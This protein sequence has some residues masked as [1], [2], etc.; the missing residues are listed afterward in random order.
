MCLFPWG[1]LIKHWCTSWDMVGW[2]TGPYGYTSP[3]FKRQWGSRTPGV[4][5]QKSITLIRD[6]SGARDKGHNPLMI[7]VTGLAESPFAPRA[8]G[9][10]YGMSHE[11][12]DPT[13][14]YMVIG[15]DVA[16]K[17][18]LALIKFKYVSPDI[19]GK[20]TTAEAEE[21]TENPK[22]QNIAKDLA[23]IHDKLSA[24]T[25]FS[26]TN[27]WVDWIT[28]ASQQMDSADCVACAGA[29]ASLWTV[30]SVLSQAGN[31]DCLIELHT[32]ENPSEGCKSWVTIFP[33]SQPQAIP[34]MF[35]PI[36]GDYTCFTKHLNG[37]LNV[38]SLTDSW[39]NVTFDVTTWT[40]MTKLTQA[41]S[42]IY[43][44][45]G[46]RRLLNV[47]S[48]EWMGK[49][50]SVSLIV[51]LKIVPI[52]AE[53]LSNE[54]K[55]HNSFSRSKREFSLT[56]GSPV[57]FD[58]I[59]VPRGVPDQYK[60]TDQI[61][62]GWESLFPFITVNKNVDRLNYVHFNI[63]RLTNMTRDALEGVHSQLSATSLMT[64]Q[65]RMALDMLLAE[66]GGVCAMFGQA[67]CTLI[68]NNTAPDGSF[69]RALHGLRAMS[70]ELAEHSGIDGTVGN[71]FGKYFG[72]WKGFFLSVF[73]TLVIAI[74]VFDFVDA[75]A[76]PVSDNY[77]SEASPLQ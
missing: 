42:D 16:D 18:P 52:T 69:T 73:L 6:Q 41:R 46:G 4:D 22:G 48:A 77:V 71:W 29:R 49:C 68:T 19:E 35:T 10:Y 39:C 28:T 62:A 54:V 7:S 26:Q 37:G 60:L 44:Y 64:Y 53:T 30:P 61:A 58:A 2:N 72:Q 66:K 34:P 24:E 33:G 21:V 47:L 74:V 5:L 67:C 63:Q 9:T 56:E 36:S 14:W 59:E 43:W 27:Y 31:I 38:G 3:S 57:Y 32:K 70:V 13:Q 8:V 55:R 12:S 76:S 65:N 1:R 51:P 45:C 75:A 25:G 17:D 15:V 23:V 40:N 11:K 50:T 20:P